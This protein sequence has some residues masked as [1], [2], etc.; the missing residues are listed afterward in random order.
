MIVCV[1]VRDFLRALLSMQKVPSD[2]VVSRE[3]GKSGEVFEPE[4]KIL[5]T[6]ELVKV[7]DN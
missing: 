2:L 6:R 3:V 1:S 4:V 5:G 7:K